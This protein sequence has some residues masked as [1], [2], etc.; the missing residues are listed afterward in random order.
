M[1]KIISEKD[2][3]KKKRRNQIILGIFLVV[4]MFISVIGYSFETNVQQNTNQIN[5]NQTQSINYNGF[6]F[7]G[8]NGFWLLSKDGGNFIFKY[9]PQQ[10]IGTNASL[11]PQTTFDGKIL[12]ISSPDFS[13][14]SEIRANLGQFAT[15]IENACLDKCNNET[16]VKTCDDNFII[17]SESKVS[18]ITTDKNCIFIRGNSEDLTRLTDEF[19]FKFLGIN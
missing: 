8:Q 15:G 12:Y 4:T 17:I 6:N 13:A 7:V 19:L 14:E 10:I 2:E 5:Q 3:N 16:Q 18:S 9:N 11:N 1:R